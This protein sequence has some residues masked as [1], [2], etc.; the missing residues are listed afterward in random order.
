MSGCKNRVVSLGACIIVTAVA[1]RSVE[2]GAVHPTPRAQSN[3]TELPPARI[4]SI[5]A[6][7]ASWRPPSGV[8]GM[9]LRLAAAASSRIERASPA[10]RV[11]LSVSA[12]SSDSQMASAAS[13]AAPAV[14]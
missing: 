11:L 6:A 14:P 3:R 8:S 13:P 12:S 4:S 5:T 9:A 10:A 2:G 1:E 7:A